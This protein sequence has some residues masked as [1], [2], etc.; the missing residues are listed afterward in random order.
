VGVWKVAWIEGIEAG[1][2]E[3]EEKEGLKGKCLKCSIC[4]VSKVIYVILATENEIL[5]L[6]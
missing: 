3:I 5:K 6:A 4:F 2:G 1:K